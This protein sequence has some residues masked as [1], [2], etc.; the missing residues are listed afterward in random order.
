[1]TALKPIIICIVGE[2][3]SGKSFI[4]QIL[5]DKYSIPMIESR[6]TR[7]PR[8]EGEPGHL[9]VSDKEFDTYK[10]EDKIA[11]TTFGKYRY[12]CLID[13]VS[14]YCS[15]VID[16]DGLRYLRE[17]FSSRFNIFSLRIFA[18]PSEREK[19]GTPDRI[20]RDEGRFTMGHEDFDYILHN[21]YDTNETERKVA[22][23]M[24]RVTQKFN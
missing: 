13:D 9:Y 7:P 17:H 22:K 6:T 18:Y 16:E 4:A 3:G 11:F 23:M 12:C 8:F 1:M 2:S 19:R 20:A 14:P 10:E 15:Y 21:N 5:E 24:L